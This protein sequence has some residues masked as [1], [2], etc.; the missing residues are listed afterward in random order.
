M[1][2][3]SIE[4]L[5]KD[6]LIGCI[7]TMNDLDMFLRE[8]IGEEKY[9]RIVGEWCKDKLKRESPEIFKTLYPSEKEDP[10]A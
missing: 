6:E 10:K 9:N 4:E 3:R 1:D 2:F 7:K 5:S 8:Y